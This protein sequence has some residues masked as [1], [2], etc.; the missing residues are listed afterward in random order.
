MRSCVILDGQCYGRT[1]ESGARASGDPVQDVGWKAEG[2]GSEAAW[3][4][5]RVASDAPGA[6]QPVSD[7]RNAAVRRRATDDA[8]ARHIPRDPPGHV[9][10]HAE[11]ELPHPPS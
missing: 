1:Y 2:L 4:E 7:A 8:E 9:H 3:P 6:R 10:G 11:G 5:A